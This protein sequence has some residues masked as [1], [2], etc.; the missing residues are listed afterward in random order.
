LRG[1]TAEAQ[2]LDASQVL[3]E[4]EST[5]EPDEGHDFEDTVPK[6]DLMGIIKLIVEQADSLFFMNLK[7]KYEKYFVDVAASAW[8]LVSGLWSNAGERL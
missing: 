7:G 5:F 8:P 4:S 2:A 6:R 3:Q 1:R